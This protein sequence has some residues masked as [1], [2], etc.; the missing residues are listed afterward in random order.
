MTKYFTSRS[1]IESFQDCPRYRYHNQ[2]NGG[3]GLVRIQKSVPLVTGGAIHRGV[4]HCMNRL[5][6][7]EDIDPDIAV[8]LAVSQYRTDCEN[9]GFY[10]KSLENDRQQKFTFEEQKA[11]TEALIRAWCYKELPQIKAR[12]KVIGVE[13]EINPVKLVDNVYLMARIDAELQ[14]IATGDYHNY[15]LK[16]VKQWGERE[17]NSYRS[18]LQGVTE[19]WA[20]EQDVE[21]FNRSVDDTVFAL[22]GLEDYNQV[23]VD[24]LVQIAAYVMKKKLDKKISA[25]RFCYLVKGVQKKPDYYGNDPDAIKITYNPLIR[26]YKNITPTG[27]TYAHSW[28]Y[29]NPNNKSGKS[30]LGQGWTPFNVWES[31]I[32]IKKWMEML[33]SGEIQPDCGDVIKQHVVTPVEYGRNEEEIEEAIGEIASQEK[34]IFKHAGLIRDFD[35]KEVKESSMEATFPHYRKH[36]EFHFGGPCEYKELCWKKEVGEDPVGS[37]LYEIRQPHHSTER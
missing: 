19:I 25:I 13:R 37:G 2:F 21:N 3:K 30:I 6:I 7:G 23:S 36:C 33:E 18:D 34:R 17:E 8:Q 20:A 27:I 16:S 9:Q 10:G 32:T 1:S 14:E 26:G 22:R 5:R 11:L 12:Y 4:E 29:P 31:N 24:K 15:S 35:I 28:F